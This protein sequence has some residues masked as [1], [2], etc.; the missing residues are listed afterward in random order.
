MDAL[1]K[2]MARLET[3]KLAL[4]AFLAGALSV[5]AMAPFFLWPIMF[6]TFPVLIWALDGICLREEA[7]EPSSPFRKRLQ[8][9]PLLGWA[10]GSTPF[11]KK[12]RRAAF[13]GWAFG[14]GYFL[15]SIYW[16]GDAF[17]VDAERYAA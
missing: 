9:T 6:V 17:Y 2:L 1:P 10:F 16:I 12:L 7:Q 13:I 5:L 4:I 8:R 11:H 3:W 14:F 15:A